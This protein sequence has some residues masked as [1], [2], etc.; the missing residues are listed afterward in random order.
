MRSPCREPQR[1]VPHLATTQVCL[2]SQ[3][4]RVQ[5][6]THHEVA[7]HHLFYWTPPPG[8]HNPYEG[9]AFFNPFTRTQLETFPG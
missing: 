7:P 2:S 3:L 6:A 8:E 9:R 5:G 1:G 4:P